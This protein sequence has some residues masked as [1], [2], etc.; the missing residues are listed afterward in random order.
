[1][2]DIPNRTEDLKERFMELNAAYQGNI[3]LH[4]A[5]ENMLDNLFEERLAK[6]DLLP[7]GMKGNICWW[8]PLILT[9]RWG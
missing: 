3:I 5:A 2:E 1:M 9:H 8:K 6:N 7:L 4:L